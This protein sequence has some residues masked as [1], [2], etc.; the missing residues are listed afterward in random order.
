MRVRRLA[1][2]VAVLVGGAL[3]SAA[4]A[5]AVTPVT[6]CGTDRTTANRVPDVDTG[7]NFRIHVL[8]A[9]P[10]DGPDRFSALASAIATEI[11]AID[12]WWRGQDAARTPRFDLF[13]FPGCTT[14]FGRLDLGF[15]RL[16]RPGSAYANLNLQQLSTDLVAFAPANVKNIVYYDGPT[17]EPDVCGAASRSERDG[18]IRGFAFVWLQADCEVDVGSGNLTA[19]VAVHELT[20]N[21]GAVP[22]GA[23][24]ECPAPDDGHVCESKSD[25]LYPFV[26][27]GASISREILDVGRD[28]YYGHSGSWWDVQ[29]SPWLMHFPLFPL[30][31]TVSGTPGA[32]T[33]D[34]GGILCPTTCSATL[35]N[36]VKTTLSAEPGAGQRLVAWGGACSGTGQCEV[37]MDAAKS[38]TATFAVATFALAVRVTGRGVVRSA[39]AGLACS[40]SCSRAFA[41]ESTVR[42]TAKASKSYRFA[43]WGGACKGT[44]AC[45]VKLSSAKSVR[46][47]FRKRT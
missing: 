36:G 22:T 21:L 12:E 15:A 33:S 24:H 11:S 34:V 45:A 27:S 8:Y 38:V 10:S 4:P 26:T 39:P 3:W 1:P 43:G 40:K 30:T 37:T 32:V 18:G 5:A 25:L 2:I 44:R 28:D 47:T 46:A 6:W 23:P 14:Q 20:H 35:E 19:E 7:S 41:A 9:A 29:D 42:L 17:T 31:V 16:P 13:G